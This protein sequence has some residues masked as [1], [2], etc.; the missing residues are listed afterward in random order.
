MKYFEP[1]VTATKLCLF[2]LE[3]VTSKIKEMKQ[4]DKFLLSKLLVFQYGRT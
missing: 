4:F 3:K 2:Q 1:F